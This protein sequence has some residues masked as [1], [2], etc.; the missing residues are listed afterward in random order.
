MAEFFDVI[1]SVLTEDIGDF[2]SE[3]FNPFEVN[4]NID[5]RIGGKGLSFDGKP[6]TEIKVDGTPG[7]YTIQFND[8]NPTSLEEFRN[9]WQGKPFDSEAEDPLKEVPDIE[10]AMRTVF[11]LP[12][13][14][15]PSPELKKF[16]DDQV[17]H[18]LE[19]N[20]PTAQVTGD[21]ATATDATN[22]ADANLEE[23]VNNE[24]TVEGKNKVTR[25]HLRERFGDKLDE[26]LDK[27][28]KDLED[29]KKGKTPESGG[30]KFMKIVKGAFWV[31]LSAGIIGG[32]ISIY[33]VIKK[34]QQ[35]LNGCWV[36]LQ[37][38]TR[39]KI[40]DLTCDSNARKTLKDGLYTSTTGQAITFASV[41]ESCQTGVDKFQFNRC[42]LVLPFDQSNANSGASV[43][44]KICSSETDCK[45]TTGTTNYSCTKGRCDNFAGCPTDD[46]PLGTTM[47]DKK[48]MNCYTSK[49]LVETNNLLTCINDKSAG[50]WCSDTLCNS[51]YVRLPSGAS[52]VCVSVSFAGAASDWFDQ[53]MSGVENFLKKILMI[54]LYVVLGIIG[55]AL[56]IG[57]IKLIINKAMGK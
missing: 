55:V 43:T 18:Y 10:E 29:L 17:N 6:V 34:H 28:Q 44:P 35:A 5:N 33:D 42:P 36:T 30:G 32:V 23:A 45:G 2:A 22:K 50:K 8:G 39:Y 52:I 20:E 51:T 7:K 19:V 26:K 13:D 14:W 21:D 46:W 11:D 31:A 9:N 3:E 53:A 37:N 47:E 4:K 54:V 49:E 16:N 24:E 25:E 27:L 40:K 38:G 15:E 57:L 56:V 41:C 12:D 1:D 48:C